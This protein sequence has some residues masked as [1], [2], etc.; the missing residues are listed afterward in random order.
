MLKKRPL[1]F[2]DTLSDLA[3]QASELLTLS[4][5]ALFSPPRVKSP[6]EP[7]EYNSGSS[8]ETKRL[9]DAGGG[10]VV[11]V[12]RGGPGISGNKI[13]NTKQHKITPGTVLQAVCSRSKEDGGS[14]R[15]NTIA[16]V[17]ISWVSS[18]LSSDSSSRLVP[19]RRTARTS[20]GDNQSTASMQF[21]LGS[22]AHAESELRFKV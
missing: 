4:R 22:Q 14:S 8:E 7:I 20:A 18:P 10:K 21:D 16:S 1:C 2:Q 15:S 5:E 19:A 17:G 3:Q 12:T 6:Y 9:R 11:A 13:P